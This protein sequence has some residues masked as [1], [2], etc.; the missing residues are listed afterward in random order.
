MGNVQTAVETKVLPDAPAWDVSRILNKTDFDEETVHSCWRYWKESDLV[1]K[2]MMT[3]ENFYLLLD[4]REEQEDE[5]RQAKKIFELLDRDDDEKL[6][7]PG[8]NA[9]VG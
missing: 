7:F 8:K 1:S 9:F 3:E 4:I 2:G 5:R 6:E